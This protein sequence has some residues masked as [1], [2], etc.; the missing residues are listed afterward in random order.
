MS[1]TAPPG[2]LS[3]ADRDPAAAL[4]SGGSPRTRLLQ[5]TPAALSQRAEVGGTALRVS[6]PRGP[7]NCR[8]RRSESQGRSRHPTLGSPRLPI[9]PRD[10][11]GHSP[12]ARGANPARTPAGRRPLLPPRAHTQPPAAARTAG[13]AQTTRRSP[14]APRSLARTRGPGAPARRAPPGPPLRALPGRVLR[15]SEPSLR[16]EYGAVRYAFYS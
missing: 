9:A 13:R 12:P 16:P 6:W 2:P 7:R 10:P 8:S 14:G 1:P 5:C 11:A 15:R 4:R 3:R